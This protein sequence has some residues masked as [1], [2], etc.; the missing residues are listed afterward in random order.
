LGPRVRHDLIASAVMILPAYAAATVVPRFIPG[1]AGQ[2]LGV[3]LAAAI[4]ITVYVAT[5]ARMKSDELE[6]LRN[7]FTA[8]AGR[9]AGTG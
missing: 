6:E 2:L 9:P 7:A 8:R 5:Q 1:R 3:S 4:G